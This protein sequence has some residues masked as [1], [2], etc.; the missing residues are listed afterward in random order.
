MKQ[1][2]LDKIAKIEEVHGPLEEPQRSYNS[3]IYDI[4]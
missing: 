2:F 3:S 1:E 4:E